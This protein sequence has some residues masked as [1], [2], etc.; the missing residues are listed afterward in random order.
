MNIFE[1][2]YKNHTI[3]LCRG[4][5]GWNITVNDPDGHSLPI[6]LQWRYNERGDFVKDLQNWRTNA[7]RSIKMRF[8]AFDDI[9]RS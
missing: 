6:S 9:I 3:T 5:G 1:H 7:E 4:H 2:T 8:T